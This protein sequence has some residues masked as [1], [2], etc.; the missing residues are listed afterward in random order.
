MSIIP[1]YIYI[2][3]FYVAYIILYC[4]TELLQKPRG[5]SILFSPEPDRLR[6]TRRRRRGV[7][8]NHRQKPHVGPPPQS[9]I[10]RAKGGN[11]TA[12]YYRTRAHMLA[13][14]SVR[15]SR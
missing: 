7:P 14:D 4:Y 9:L 2:L 11:N 8:M 12:R 5:V 15:C 3:Y 13:A 1:I 6:V 10:G